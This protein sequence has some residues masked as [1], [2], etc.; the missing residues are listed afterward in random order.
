MSAKSIAPKQ[1]TQLDRF[2]LAREVADFMFDATESWQQRVDDND[3]ESC[4]LGTE[5]A[6]LMYGIMAREG[7]KASPG[8]A[9]IKLL[10]TNKD[11]MRRLECVIT[12]YED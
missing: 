2:K 4:E 10:R 3:P 5:I 12:I 7:Y 1:P 11:L 8:S 6:Y 9:L